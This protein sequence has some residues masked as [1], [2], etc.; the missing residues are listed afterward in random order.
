MT[1]PGTNRLDI[2]LY[3]P[4]MAGGIGGI[5][6]WCFNYPLDYVKSLL[7]TDSF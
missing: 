5:G 6:Y 3:V 2:P 1:P 7:Q 4:L